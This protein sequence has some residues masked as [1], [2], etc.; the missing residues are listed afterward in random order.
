MGY[1]FIS[2]SS[3]NEDVKNELKKILDSNGFESWIA[4]DDV[5]V[6]SDYPSVIVNAIKNC[7][8]T[9]L[10][11]TSASMKS[12]WVAREIERA[13]NYER[14]VI[15]VM[16]EDLKLTPAFELF[17]STSQIVSIPDLS[18]GGN[19]VNRVLSAVNTFTAA[20]DFSKQDLMAEFA[21]FTP[22][23]TGEEP[24]VLNKIS[25]FLNKKNRKLI[26]AGIAALLV[27]VMII[28]AVTSAVNNVKDTFSNGNM[29]STENMQ[30][31]FDALTSQINNNKNPLTDDTSDNTDKSDDTT[32]NA[33]ENKTET[34]STNQIPEKYKEDVLALQYADALSLSNKTIRLKVGEYSTPGAAMV[35][36]NITI[37][38]TDTTV[39]V[40]EGKLVK[41]VAKGE[42]FIIVDSQGMSGTAYYVIVEE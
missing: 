42:A 18:K 25:S 2:Y 6:G 31:T 26:L 15:T 36:P 9:V 40:G 34:N 5:P 21:T 1:V 17:T 32:E 14:P 35:W 20:S 39:A 24:S 19:D 16:L 7:S 29:P 3:K 37:Y 22:T 41:G 13:I 27:L 8:C 33:A 28:S 11:L 4:P 38:S 30:D 10:L 23:A 12:K